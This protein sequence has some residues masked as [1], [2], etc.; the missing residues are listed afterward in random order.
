MELQ[1]TKSNGFSVTLIVNRKNELQVIDNT[2]V[3]W[4][5]LVDCDTLIAQEVELIPK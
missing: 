2:Q 4:K 3:D 5:E 1:L